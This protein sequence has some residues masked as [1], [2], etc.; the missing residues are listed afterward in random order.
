MRVERAAEIAKYYEQ[1]KNPGYRLGKSRRVDIDRVIAELTPKGT[2]LDV[3]TGRGETLA[4]AE[5]HGLTAKGTEVVDYLLIPG[6]VV[7]AEAH[8]L[9]FPDSSFDHVTCFD[10][11]EHL[12][13]DD[14]AP[15]LREFARVAKTTVTVSAATKSHRVNGVE[16]HV[17]AMPLKEW[18]GVILG[19]WFEHDG[20][21]HGN[22]GVNSGCWQ[23]RKAGCA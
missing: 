6:R 19:A 11:L 8:S 1:Y 9:P 14:I 5:T 12:V 3:G 17:S 18:E 22:A 15:A 10:V 16:L 21:R 13:M 2:L 23:M 4:I 7:Y 20:Y